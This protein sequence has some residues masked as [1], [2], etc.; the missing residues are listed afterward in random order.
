MT[1]VVGSPP[2]T[3]KEDERLRALALSR[4]SVAAMA[5]QMK[6]SKAAVRNR[7]R[8][9]K[10]VMAKSRLG[11]KAKGKKPECDLSR[12]RCPTSAAFCRGARR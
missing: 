10:I 4:I 2:W 11:V 5:E 6:R 3:P 9:L 8:R 7:A 12:Y 1:P